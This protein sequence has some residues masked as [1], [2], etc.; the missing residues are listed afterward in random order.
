MPRLSN[1]QQANLV[2]NKS[3]RK[4]C[5]WTPKSLV[6]IHL[7]MVIPHTREDD[8]ILEPCKG[9]GAYYDYFQL[10]FPSSRHEWCEI[11]EGKDFFDYIGS[12]DVIVTN[13]PFSLLKQFIE[14]MI[15]LNPRVIS[16]LLNAY[17]MT[18]CRIKRFNEAGYFLVAYHLTRVNRWFG[19]SVVVVFSR[20]A[21]ANI[22]G[23]D[24]TK[25]ALDV[26]A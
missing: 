3:E 25:H 4:D 16:I 13:P 9:K 6:K 17:A 10:A 18:P 15:M 21:T 2:R 14:R 7:E 26:E 11:T 19:C 22:I 24:V 5:Y 23:F 12:P 1:T 20:E 8:L